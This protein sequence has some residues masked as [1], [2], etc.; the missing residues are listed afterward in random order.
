MLLCRHA[1]RSTFANELHM[2]MTVL[3]KV[4]PLP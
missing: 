2:V 4:L 1:S 3:G